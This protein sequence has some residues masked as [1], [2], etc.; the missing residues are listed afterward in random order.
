MFSK[1]TENY[2]GES[3]H[4]QNPQ[5]ERAQIGQKYSNVTLKHLP[6]PYTVL[7]QANKQRQALNT[8]RDLTHY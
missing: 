7:Q 6:L 1:F 4:K 8:Q 3:L 5:N 2:R